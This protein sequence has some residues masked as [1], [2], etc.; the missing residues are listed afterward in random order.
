MYVDSVGRHRSKSNATVSGQVLD[1]VLKSRKNPAS[2]LSHE[3]NQHVV[4]YLRGSMRV[5]L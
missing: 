1:H 5:L 4:K 3:W 2:A